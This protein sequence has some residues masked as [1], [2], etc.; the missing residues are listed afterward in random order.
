MDY[1]VNIY[2][3]KDNGRCL[4][5]INLKSI[6]IFITGFRVVPGTGH[7]IIVHMPKGMGTD[8]KYKNIEWKYVREIITDEY[9]KNPITSGIFKNLSQ[10]S[11]KTSTNSKSNTQGD[12]NNKLF[13]SLYNYES[14]TGDCQAGIIL[15]RRKKRIEGF[16]VKN[17]PEGG[18]SVYLPKGMKS[19][20]YDEI[21]WSDVQRNI[22]DQYKEE[23]KFIESDAFD[24]S[25]KKNELRI[26]FHDLRINYYYNV[27]ISSFSEHYKETFTLV[28]SGLKV[29]FIKTEQF[30]AFLE[31]FK[32][33]IEIMNNNA[34]KVFEEETITLERDYG[35]I[36]SLGECT[37]RSLTLK[38]DF[39]LPNNTY[40]WKNFI[41]RE[42]TDGSVI[43]NAPRG[44]R[45]KNDMYPWNVLCERI[46][47]DYRAYKEFN[48]GNPYNIVEENNIVEE[49][50]NKERIPYTKNN[51]FQA[52]DVKTA[53]E[54]RLNDLGR[55]LNAKNTPFA[56]RPHSI[57]KLIS[58]NNEERKPNPW[59]VVYAINSPNG[60][61]GAFEIEILVWISRLKYVVKTMIL[62]LVLSGFISAPSN[63]NIN[64][65]KM[66]DIM[67]RLYKYNLIETSQF[68]AVNDDGS[69][70][71][72]SGKSVYR[73]HTL[74]STGYSL[75]KEI[76]RNPD[77]M[78]PFSILADGNTVKKHLVANQWLIYW[79][80]H[81]FQSDILD[82][83]I[84]QVITM[85]GPEWNAVRI[86]AS[87][88]LES[89]SIIAEPIRRCEDFEEESKP[90]EIKEK[91]LRL[92]NMLDN[93]DKL[94]TSFLREQIVF[95]SR[96]IICLICEDVAHIEEIKEYIIEI[97]N[98]KPNQRIWFTTDSFMFN[99]D[100]RGKRIMEIKD[101]DLEFVDLENTIGVR[102]VTMEERGDNKFAK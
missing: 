48:E 89:I 80:T 95:P 44:F 88:N 13:V 102:E 69:P 66:T 16:A 41:L 5:D 35:L 90:E 38:V 97:N 43:I 31:T 84:N 85:I 2:D 94:Y 25:S 76:G 100:S 42:Q 30:S 61:I 22:L 36:M 53:E 64:A 52:L 17:M 12:I 65:N 33:D 63:R 83:S 73:I 26:K 21:S 28:D 92:I 11:L 27:L 101:G 93:N 86:Y 29:E 79:L 91:L 8:W 4:A 18:V 56:F 15:P 98:L 55:V 20:T 24:T 96:P 70:I 87:I 82:Y 23:R 57:L 68:I 3:I 45:W 62:D 71:E 74:G 10:E 78:S 39:I 99:Y 7:G 49:V 6:N 47:K 40:H 46:R 19:W 72:E 51:S 37:G 1:E 77:R 67:N 34:E 58:V 81:Y 14:E 50:N 75:L 32:I 60:G 54:R 59:Q 9:L